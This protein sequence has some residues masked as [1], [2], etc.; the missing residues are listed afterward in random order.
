MGAEPV[1]LFDLI[2]SEMPIRHPKQGC[3]GNKSI[4]ESCIEKRS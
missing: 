1:A 4:C 3:Q 2:L